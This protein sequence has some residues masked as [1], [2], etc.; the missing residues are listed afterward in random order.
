MCCRTINSM[1]NTVTGGTIYIGVSDDGIVHG[2]LLNQYKV[3]LISL[4]CDS[5]VLM[6]TVTSASHHCTL[7]SI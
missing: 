3:L 1:L 6:V 5:S 7:S 4:A 2:V